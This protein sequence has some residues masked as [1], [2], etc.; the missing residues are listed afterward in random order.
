VYKYVVSLALAVRYRVH[1]TK[2]YRGHT[3]IGGFAQ[4]SNLESGPR[5]R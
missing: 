4:H 1:W 5:P 3:F 2:W